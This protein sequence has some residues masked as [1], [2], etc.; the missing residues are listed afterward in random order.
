MRHLTEE[1]IT[2]LEENRRC[3]AD[4]W[5]LIKVSETFAPSQLTEVTFVGHCTLGDLSGSH[6][7]RYG[8]K[9]SN[10]ICHALL[11]D[12]T[13]GDGAYIANVRDCI[14]DYDIGADVTIS[15]VNAIY[16]SGASTFGNGVSVPVLNETGGIEVPLSRKLTAQIAYLLVTTPD[17]DPVHQELVRLISADVEECRSERGAI[18]DNVRIV[19]TGTI[20][21]GYIGDGSIIDGASILSNFSLCSRPG[22]PAVVGNGVILSLIHI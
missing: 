8:I 2:L 19:N 18:G 12:T 11:K 15:N 5:S 16:M 1:E 3:Q 22:Y 9:R 4:D 20:I 10:G 13:I 6:I 7:D 21:D 17:S 14:S